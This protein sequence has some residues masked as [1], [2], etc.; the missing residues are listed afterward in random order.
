[1]RMFL[2]KVAACEPLAVAMSGVRLGE[3]L[4]QIGVDDP[5]LLGALAAKVGLSGH[6]AVVTLDERSARAR[7]RRGRGRMTARRRQRHHRRVVAVRR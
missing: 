7:A 2:R 1:M 5:P 3:R 6:A 4:L